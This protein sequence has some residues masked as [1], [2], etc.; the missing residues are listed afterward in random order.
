MFLVEST[1]NVAR[2]APL[3]P[4]T[5][6]RRPAHDQKSRT[7]DVFQFIP[8]I[9]L[10]SRLRALPALP[11]NPP[12]H[13]P[14]GNL[15]HRRARSPQTASCTASAVY[16]RSFKIC[17]S[18]ACRAP[19]SGQRNPAACRLASSKFPALRAKLIIFACSSPACCFQHIQIAR[20][21]GFQF[22][23]RLFRHALARP[24][25]SPA[26]RARLPRARRKASL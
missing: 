10:K 13:L 16:D 8:Q 11:R 26:I 15:A 5:S 9:L 19:H 21:S 14:R 4:A 6:K 17:V 12:A 23:R 3:H 25:N 1:K 18:V 22:M 24:A 7:T 20:V 2:P